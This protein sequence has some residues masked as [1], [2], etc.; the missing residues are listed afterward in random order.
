[1]IMCCSLIFTQSLTHFLHSLRHSVCFYSPDGLDLLVL[2]GDAL[3]AIVTQL[4]ELGGQAER[5]L[6]LSLAALQQRHATF[7]TNAEYTQI[8]HKFFEK[9]YW[10]QLIFLNGVI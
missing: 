3:L 8:F 5:L 10:I 6:L 4:V 1:M 9:K 2:D 7:A